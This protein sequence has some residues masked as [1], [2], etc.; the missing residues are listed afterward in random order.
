MKNHIAA[1]MIGSALIA[2]APAGASISTAPNS[3]VMRAVRYADLDLSTSRGR[4]KL[5]RRVAR[6]L[7]SVCGSYANLSVEEQDEVTRCRHGAQGK[8]APQLARLLAAYEPVQSA[9]LDR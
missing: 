3:E 5:D 8:L 1:L 7:E 6:A 4:A 9:M 2:A